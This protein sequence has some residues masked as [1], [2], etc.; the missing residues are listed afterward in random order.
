MVSYTVLGSHRPEVY[1]VRVVTECHDPSFWDIIL[2]QVS[3]PEYPRIFI[4]PRG[5]TISRQTV[6]EYNTAEFVNRF[7]SWQDDI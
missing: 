6:D 4:G 2:E 1:N 5:F 3:W 7:L